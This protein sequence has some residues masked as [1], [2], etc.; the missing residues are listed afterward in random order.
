[1]GDT[2]SLLVGLV[3]SILVI[4]FI[5]AGPSYSYYPVSAAPAV[6]FGILLLPL[7]DTLRVFSVRIMQGRSPFTP[8]RNHIHHLFLRR[9]FTHKMITGICV[10]STVLV[11]IAAFAFQEI[12]NTLLLGL[13]MSFFF[14]LVY[15][16]IGSKRKSKLRVI[17]GEIDRVVNTD[18]DEG[19]ITFLNKDTV[20]VKE[21]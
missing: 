19:L 7:M 9:G 1:M 5:Q 10:L 12:G 15:F 6:G 17:K 11:S 2:G 13:L 8:D 20:F 18:G 3:N 14:L 21:D 16:V 4:K